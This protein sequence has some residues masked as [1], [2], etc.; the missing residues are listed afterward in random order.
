MVNANY[1][2]YE[3]KVSLEEMVNNSHEEFLDLLSV[4]ATDTKLLMDI[5]YEIVDVDRLEQLVILSVH[6]DTSLI[7]ESED[8]DNA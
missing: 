5:S 7:E 1:Q 2:I 6:G 4:L 8:D 3:V